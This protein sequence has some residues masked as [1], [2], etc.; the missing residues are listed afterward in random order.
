MMKHISYLLASVLVAV[1]A[2]AAEPMDSVPVVLNS[3][4]MDSITAGAATGANALAIANATILA[5]TGART[6]SIAATTPTGSGASASGGVASASAIGG[7]AA[8]TAITTQN[9]SGGTV[10]VGGNVSV[11]GLLGQSQGAVIVTVNRLFYPL[12]P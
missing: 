12:S 1:S 6:G 5:V 9:N 7:G 4:Q 8:G 11:G 2:V 3:T 10:V